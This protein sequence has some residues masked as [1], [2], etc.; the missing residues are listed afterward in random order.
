MILNYQRICRTP[1]F[2]NFLMKGHKHAF[3]LYLKSTTQ[4]IFPIMASYGQCMLM[5]IEDAVLRLNLQ[6]LNGKK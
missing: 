2:N 5:N 3:V 1:Q 4:K 6:I